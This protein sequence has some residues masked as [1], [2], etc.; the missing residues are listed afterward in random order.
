LKLKDAGALDAVI[1]R[2]DDDHRDGEVL[3][4]E[5]FDWYASRH[6]VR[7]EGEPLQVA[8]HHARCIRA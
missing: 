6:F 5:H 7:T 2:S 8:S 1:A 4:P 3:G